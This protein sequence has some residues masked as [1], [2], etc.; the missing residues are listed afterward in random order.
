MFYFKASLLVFYWLEKQACKIRDFK[1]ETFGVETKP[2]S[3]VKTYKL[4]LFK[5]NLR[6][7]KWDTFLL[8]LF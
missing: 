2:E 1:V 4:K 3:F 8:H 5:K 6:G 7:I